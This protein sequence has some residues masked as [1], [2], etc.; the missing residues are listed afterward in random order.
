MPFGVRTTLFHERWANRGSE[1]AGTATR[2]TSPE[3]FRA[4]HALPPHPVAAPC[5][6][7]ASTDATTAFARIADPSFV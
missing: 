6:G 1:G 4:C 2:T 3:G 7:G 5:Q